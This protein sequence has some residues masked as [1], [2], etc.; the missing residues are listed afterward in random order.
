MYWIQLIDVQARMALKAEAAKLYLSYVWWVL[1]PML[2]VAVFYFVFSYLLDRGGA[3]FLIFLLCGKVPYLWFSKSVMSGSESILRNRSLI[4]NVNMPK[5]IFPY[6]AIVEVL[7]KEWFVFLVLLI[8]LVVLGLSPAWFWFWIF[9][10]V[11]VQLLLISVCAQ[12]GALFVTAMQ[13]FRMIIS[14][15]MLFLMFGSGIF[16]DVNSISNVETR[17]L[18][19]T[20]NPLAFLFDAYRQIL[21]HGVMFDVR[22]MAILGGMSLAGI[23]IMH[24]IYTKMNYKIADQVLAA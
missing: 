3:N 20:L 23:L 13:D 6:S 1:E 2:Y 4:G 19:L 21:I 11:L 18:F 7:Y 14:L 15:A 8:A 22:H 16:W 10:I 5:I 24:I 12:V 9:P 17:E